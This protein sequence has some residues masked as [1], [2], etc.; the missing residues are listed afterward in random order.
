M[1]NRLDA[2]KYGPNA[3]MK[4]G[5][6]LLPMTDLQREHA[7]FKKAV[8]SV[9]YVLTKRHGEAFNEALHTERAKGCAHNVPFLGKPP[10]FSGNKFDWKG[11]E[12]DAD[13][14]ANSF[15]NAIKNYENKC[16]EENGMNRF[17]HVGIEQEFFSFTDQELRDTF[18]AITLEEKRA[19]STR[20]AHEFMQILV[21]KD[22]IFL[23]KP[24]SYKQEKGLT[25]G[26]MFICRFN[27]KG[28]FLNDLYN[29]NKRQ[30]A[31]QVMQTRY[32]TLHQHTNLKTTVTDNKVALDN[33]NK[34][35]LKKIAQII[36]AAEFTS[37]S[38]FSHPDLK[39]E[40]IYKNTRVA[41]DEKNRLY[42]SVNKRIKELK[43]HYK[44]Q[45]FSQNI[46]EDMS[47]QRKLRFM[48]EN[49]KAN[50]RGVNLIDIKKHVHETYAKANSYV[51]FAERLLALGLE[52][53]PKWSANKGVFQGFEIGHKGDSRFYIPVSTFDIEIK[54]H[55]NL[56]FKNQNEFNKLLNVSIKA[57]AAYSEFSSSKLKL[58]NGETIEQW[59]ERLKKHK[60]GYFAN[61]YREDG[62][63]YYYGTS[64]HKA[65][66]INAKE[67]T[68][69]LRNARE[70][71]IKALAEILMS[72]GVK[73]LEV[74]R[75]HDKHDLQLIMN[76]FSEY[77]IKLS[78]HMITEENENSLEA[79]KLQ[80]AMS[81]HKQNIDTF[82]KQCIDRNNKI[83]S[84]KPYLTKADEVFSYENVYAMLP[85]Y[86][87]A[88]VE[89]ANL[90]VNYFLKNKD[91]LLKRFENDKETIEYLNGIFK[92]NSM[93]VE[94]KQDYLV[95]RRGIKT[96]RVKLK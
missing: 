13:I 14:F 34:T 91:Y 38:D 28:E 50:E 48:L 58:Q 94:E 95:R 96:G 89:I 64:E 92:I 71:D 20:L 33:L 15:C 31:L 39:F 40:Y 69:I 86:A 9:K 11:Y 83:I 4:Y 84:I 78:G 36:N 54:K 87:K 63:S 26:H 60:R 45:K 43:I 17:N 2:Q 22:Y 8:D 82:K 46:I 21:G 12:N 59:L 61:L 10:V 49:D 25:D 16:F 57:D 55:F 93:S 81:S 27:S 6:E 41:F 76:I 52:I 19:A 7:A 68:V 90:D 44:G 30:Y 1:I 29:F 67:G 75:C 51:D 73:E 37:L 56:E 3:S 79:F 18:G 80:K 23:H 47:A 5:G 72:R 65:F 42:G 88:G 53:Q 35:D 32:P 62:D 85:H 74:K 70:R 24:H 66:S 77:S